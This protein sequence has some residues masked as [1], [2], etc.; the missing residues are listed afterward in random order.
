[1]KYLP[2][3]IGLIGAISYFGIFETLA[4][5]EPNRFATLSNAIATLGYH[6]PLAIFIMGFFSGGLAV[7][8]FWPWLQ[9]PLG[10]GGG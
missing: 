7:H 10:S 4:F 5:R 9:N 1:M 6:W 2:W 8:F 3:I